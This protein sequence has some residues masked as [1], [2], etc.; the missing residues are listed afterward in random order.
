MH[1]P[2]DVFGSNTFEAHFLREELSNKTIHILVCASLPRAIRV[3]K[4]MLCIEALGD[5]FMLCELLPLSVV[6][7]C[8]KA[9]KGVSK[10]IIVSDTASAVLRV[11]MPMSE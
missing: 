8:T 2:Y 7:V 4:E 1:C 3:C 5:S 9:E 10:E 11:T 6:S